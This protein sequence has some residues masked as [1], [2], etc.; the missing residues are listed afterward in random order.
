LVFA[1]AGLAALSGADEPAAAGGCSMKAVQRSQVG[2]N[3]VARI[4]NQFGLQGRLHLA[5]QLL[6]LRVLG[7]FENRHNLLQLVF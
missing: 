3:A 5:A 6:E 4:G 1:G 7:R 2:F